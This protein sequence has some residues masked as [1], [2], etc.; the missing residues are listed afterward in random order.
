M[1]VW[2]RRAVERG[3]RVRVSTYLVGW[4]HPPVDL[5][6]QLRHAL[7]CKLLSMRHAHALSLLASQLVGKCLVKGPCLG[8]HE[9]LFALPIAALGR[10]ELGRA[11]RL[12]EC[13]WPVAHSWHDNTSLLVL[14]HG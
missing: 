10:A 4:S 14:L 7:V 5:S 2:V 11:L 12:L 6:G 1:R 13:S 9:K 8:T 3:V